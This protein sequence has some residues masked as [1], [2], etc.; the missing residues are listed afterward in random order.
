ML[1]FFII[2]ALLLFVMI[3]LF[4]GV[5]V[6]KQG[7]YFWKKSPNFGRPIRYI[8]IH[9][10]GLTSD[11]EALSYLRDKSKEVSCHY[12]IDSKGTLFQ[13]VRDSDI[14]WHAGESFWGNDKSLNFTSLGIELFNPSAGNGKAYTAQQYRTL[15]KLLNL[16]INK[17]DIPVSN[18]LGHCDIAPDRKTDPGYLFDWDRLYYANVC[19]LSRVQKRGRCER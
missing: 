10:T 2:L 5:R 13:L 18:V 19:D 7:I 6:G 17:Y 8:I 3:L 9:G 11:K 4:F 14:A 15:I 1:I 16:L 12:F